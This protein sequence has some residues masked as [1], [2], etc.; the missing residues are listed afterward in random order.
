M[1][2]PGGKSSTTAMPGSTQH[3]QFR[4]EEKAEF[5]PAAE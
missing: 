1:P 5:R 3:D 4:P 2:S